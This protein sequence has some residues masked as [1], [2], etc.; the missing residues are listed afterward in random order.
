VTDHRAV[1]GDT[2]DAMPDVDF[3]DPD[4]AVR[5]RVREMDLS[6]LGRRLDETIRDDAVADSNV[7]ERVASA[8]GDAVDDGALEGSSGTDAEPTA[9][10]ASTTDAEPTTDDDGAE[11]DQVSM[12][13]FS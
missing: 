3:A 12:E 6:D 5:E 1:G 7:R 11:R 9:D 13:D 4:A 10:A 2:A 8:V